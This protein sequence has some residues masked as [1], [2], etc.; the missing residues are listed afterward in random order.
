MKSV[1][2]DGYASCLGLKIHENTNLFT[3]NSQLLQFLFY[4]HGSL[5]TIGNCSGDNQQ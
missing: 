5:S 2:S 3:E 1:N 4:S